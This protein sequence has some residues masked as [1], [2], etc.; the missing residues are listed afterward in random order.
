VNLCEVDVF[1][2]YS[3][4]DQPGSIAYT[5]DETGDIL[6]CV[7]HANEFASTGERT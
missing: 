1:E 5:D 4:C 2:G 6:L 3:A 7:K